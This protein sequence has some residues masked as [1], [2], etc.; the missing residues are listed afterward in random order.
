MTAVQNIQA[1]TADA[2]G[3]R[4]EIPIRPG[5]MLPNWSVVCSA[6]ARASLGAI[7]EVLKV[8]ECWTG[9]AEAVDD[10]RRAILEHYIGKGRAPSVTQLSIAT[11][12]ASNRLDRLLRELETRDLIVLDRTSGA[13]TGAYPFTER[14]TGHHLRLDGHVLN[15]MCAIDALGAGA[16]AGRD[17]V[18]ESR[19]RACGAPIQVETGEGGNSLKAHA[20]ENA[21]VWSGIEYADG[22]AATSL[23]TVMAF[24]CSDEHLGSWRKTN[25]PDTRGSRLSMDEA[26]QVGMAIFTPMLAPPVSDP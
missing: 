5:V 7:L 19:C 26:H 14:E 22:C 25:H 4:I 20:P 15:A 21:V 1:P 6:T 16:M 3:K 24:F 18:I 9:I 8:E 17:L 11:N 13:I 10:L 23:C 12:L 2:S